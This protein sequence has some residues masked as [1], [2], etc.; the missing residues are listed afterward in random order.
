MTK[1]L[2]ATGNQGKIDEMKDLLQSVKVKIITPEDL[3]LALEVNE[4]GRTYRENAARK[5]LAFS[6]AS[7][8]LALADD[9]GL[10]VEALDGAPGV[11]SA[12]Y[13]PKPGATAKDRRDYLLAQLQGVSK[14][15]SARFHCTT[16]LASPEGEIH[17]TE[18]ICAGEI[19]SEEHGEAGF[20]YDPIFFV[21]ALGR[22]MAELSLTEKNQISHRSQA[23]KSLLPILLTYL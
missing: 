15:W 2:L 9:S 11:Y 14:P 22:T 6:A 19:I 23:I 7:S 18:G 12:R 1:L 13:S 8:L 10:E 4:D 21:S 16:A 5:A 17:F 20:G 3:H